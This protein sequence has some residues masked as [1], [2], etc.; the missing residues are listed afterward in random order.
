MV[1]KHHFE[2]GAAGGEDGLVSLE[3]DVIDGDATVAEEAPF[4]LVV[5]LLQNV[6]TMARF[7]HHLGFP[8]TPLLS[9]MTA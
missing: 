9:A 6:A 7:T 2:I 4:S 1:D 8:I 5:E 3:V